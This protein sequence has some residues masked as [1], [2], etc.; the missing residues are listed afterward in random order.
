M[1]HI[2]HYKNLPVGWIKCKMSDLC[3]ITMGQSPN[4]ETVN[5]TH[6]MEFH[7][8]KIAFGN[9]YLSLSGI[10]TSAPTKIAEAHS[11][12]LCVRAPVGIPNITEREI[13]IGRGLCAISC[14]QTIDIKF[15]FYS[16]QTMQQ[17]FEEKSTGSTFK[18]ISGDIVKNAIIP[19]PPLQEQRRIVSAIESLMEKVNEISDVCFQ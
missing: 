5:N 11:V 1:Q 19:V 6:G 3:S 17:Y 12:V 9:T 10:Y 15:L 7:Q 4:G 2:S 18:A 16:L 13:C 14:S 8:G